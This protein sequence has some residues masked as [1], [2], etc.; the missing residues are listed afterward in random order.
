MV[1][2]MLGRNAVTSSMAPN[3]PS[4]IGRSIAGH[5]TTT[6]KQA[7]ATVPKIATDSSARQ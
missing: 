5:W 7:I 1:R 2:R 3:H 4:K 6:K